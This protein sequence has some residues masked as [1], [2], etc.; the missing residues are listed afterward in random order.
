MFH[1]D[2]DDRYDRYHND[3]IDDD[4][5]NDNNTGSVL[6]FVIGFVLLV[7]IISLLGYLIWKQARREDNIQIQP[8][9]TKIKTIKPIS[10]QYGTEGVF[11]TESE[12]K[13]ELCSICIDTYRDN[14]R[15]FTLNCGHTYHKECI[16]KWY[17]KKN[18]CP[19][20]IQNT[21]ISVEV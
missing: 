6:G 18:T 9:S 5:I 11:T 20:C 4:T 7:V 1:D 3:D 16:S 17:E 19:Y 2:D 13:P 12:V 21:I 10:H 14:D 15:I 8:E